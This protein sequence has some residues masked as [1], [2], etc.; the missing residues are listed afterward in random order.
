MISSE[1]IFFLIF[2]LLARLP[3]YLTEEN[4]SVKELLIKTVVQLFPITLFT[5]TF[6]II[7]VAIVLIALSI[8]EYFLEEKQSRKKQNL[9][10]LRTIELIILI[11]VSSII[12]SIKLPVVFCSN[13]NEALTS[14]Q[15]NYVITKN[16]SSLNF[17]TIGIVILGA[18]FLLNEVN[19]PIRGLLD[20]LKVL[21]GNK[22]NILKDEL[23]AGR[24]IGMLERIIVYIFVL[25]GEYAALGLILAAKAYAR[26][27]RM[28]N[29]DFAE[30]V[31]IG[32][33]ISTLSAL[34]IGLF[35]KYLVGY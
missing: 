24:V 31:L 22:E 8:I 7:L 10:G 26:S 33:L 25:G 23:N 34:I 35:V 17:N 18:L 30:Y 16:I 27:K 21:P 9:N 20:K 5:Y 11:I 12:F 14:V 19:L 6:N 4:L 32:T 1:Y 13:I 3:V 2:I 28:D 29:Q 15:N